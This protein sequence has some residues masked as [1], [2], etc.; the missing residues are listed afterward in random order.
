M[1]PSL[2]ANGLRTDYTY[3]AFGR[4]IAKTATD[5]TGRAAGPLHRTRAERPALFNMVTS[6]ADSTGLARRTV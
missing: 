6:A 4:M 2:G 5:L 3:D 1:P